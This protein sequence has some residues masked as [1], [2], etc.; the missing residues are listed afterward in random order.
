MVKRAFL[1]VSL[2]SSTVYGATYQINV[3]KEKPLS[4]TRKQFVIYRIKKGD[5]LLKIMRKFK[6]PRGLLYKIVQ[7]NGIKN[8]NIIYAGQLI[9]LPIGTHRQEKKSNLKKLSDQRKLELLRNLGATVDNRG[10]LFIGNNKISLEK[11]PIVSFKN[12]RFLIDFTGLSQG[13]KTSLSSVGI[14]VIPGNSVDKLL[15]RV[16]SADFDSLQKN[17]TLI[18]GGNDVLTYHYDYLA[19]NRY[20][21]QRTVINTSPDTPPTLKTLLESYGISVVEPAYK[22][23]DKSEGWGDLKILTGNGLEKISQLILILSG[24]S[25]K[26]IPE[27]LLFPN[28]KLAVV[29]DYITPERRTALELQGYRVFTLSGNFLRD[30]EGILSLIPVAN[31]FVEL[32]LYEPP[33]TKGKRS[34]FTIKGLLISGKDKD[35]FLID[36]V[37]KLE[38]IPYL[39]YRGVNIIIY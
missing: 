8:P 26:K 27:G 34:T 11:N 20:T 21:G 10:Y 23:I 9:K 7:I 22:L 12:N 25:G 37:D 35:W 16:I 4:E 2:I 29:Y 5:T 33:G 17:G 32:V 3:I 28:S 14:S 18:L 6:I 24:E 13:I 36:T 39:R 1:I 15:E 38:E 19:Y 31:K 30:V